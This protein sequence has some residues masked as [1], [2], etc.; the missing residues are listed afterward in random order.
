VLLGVDTPDGVRSGFGLLMRR[1]RAVLG[2][3]EPDG[4]LVQQQVTDGVEMIAGLVIDPQFGPFVL[5]GAGG[6]LAELLDDVVLRPAPVDEGEVTAMIAELR[7]RRLL[8]GFRGAPAADAGALA[9]TVAA[10]SRLGAEH[11]G[12]LAELDLNPVLVRPRGSGAVVA[13]ALAVLA[14][15]AAEPGQHAGRQA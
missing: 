11:A 5:L 8:D 7:G 12:A 2:G 1:G 15:S 14:G 3:A 9:A 4:V 10:L 13:D 6:V